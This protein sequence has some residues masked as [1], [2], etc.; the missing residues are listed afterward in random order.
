MIIC[1]YKSKESGEYVDAHEARGKTMEELAPLIENYNRESN[2]R[3]TCGAVEV[4]DDSLEAYLFRTRHDRM[5]LDREAIQDAIDHLH[6]ALDAV[7]YL[8]G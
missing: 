7:R 1:F 4:A 8:E 3:R 2:N 6:D 5:K